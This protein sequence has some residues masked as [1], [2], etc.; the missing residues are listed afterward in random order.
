MALHVAHIKNFR[1]LSTWTSK[2]GFKAGHWRSSI[3]ESCTCSPGKCVKRA[4][5]DIVPR[6][7]FCRFLC[8]LYNVVYTFNVCRCKKSS[9]PD[10]FP[11]PNSPVHV[12]TCC[13]SNGKRAM[14]HNKYVLLYSLLSRTVSSCKEIAYAMPKRVHNIFLETEIPV[15]ILQMPY[16]IYIYNFEHLC[17]SWIASGL[18]FKSSGSKLKV[19]K[20]GSCITFK[21]LALWSCRV[22]NTPF[23]H[24]FKVLKG[25]W[26][27]E[28]RS[29]VS[30][31]AVS[32]FA[33]SLH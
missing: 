19:A 15:R 20:K 24:G 7:I 14:R 32:A 28:P 11:T 12:Y 16:N 13:F 23:S 8:R 3:K 10:S 4:K 1:I 2:K 6:R 17:K 22:I 27:G 9:R 21:F 25:W 18:N 33:C 26:A 29:A 5:T 31:T 30:A